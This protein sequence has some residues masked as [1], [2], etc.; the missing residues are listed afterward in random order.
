MEVSAKEVLRDQVVRNLTVAVAWMVLYFPD[1]LER[2]SFQL[3]PA[4]PHWARD[5]LPTGFLASVLS[6]FIDDHIVIFFLFI[7]NVI[8]HPPPHPH[9][10][11]GLTK[12]S[13]YSSLCILCFWR[14]SKT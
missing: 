9:Q 3:H 11:V 6:L 8:P 7:C 5:T 12:S 1:S 2:A 14:S 4:S 13:F 10:A